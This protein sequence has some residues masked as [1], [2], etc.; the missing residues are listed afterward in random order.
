[1]WCFLVFFHF[2]GRRVFCKYRGIREPE[3]AN[4]MNYDYMYYLFKF[5]LG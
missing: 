5:Y 1:M 3:T 2:D 4:N